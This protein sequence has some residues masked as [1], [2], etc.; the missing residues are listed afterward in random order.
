MHSIIEQAQPLG[1]IQEAG[2]V[3]AILAAWAGKKAKAIL[4]ASEGGESD[5]LNVFVVCAAQLR[6]LLLPLR[7]E[8]YEGN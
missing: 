5:E 4:R 7:R 6:P 8:L 3:F 2:L 1:K